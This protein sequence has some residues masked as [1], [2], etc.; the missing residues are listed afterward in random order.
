MRVTILKR[1]V[2]PKEGKWP[3]HGC[4]S[5]V[6]AFSPRFSSWDQDPQD[7][8]LDHF[9]QFQLKCCLSAE[10]RGTISSA[11]PITVSPESEISQL[12]ADFRE[13]DEDSNFS[14]FRV[15]RFSEWPEALHWIAFPVEILT[16]PDSLELPPPFSLKTPFFHWKV[17]RRIPFPKIGSD[18]HPIIQ[19]QWW[20]MASMQSDPCQPCL[21]PAIYMLHSQSRPVRHYILHSCRLTSAVASEFQIC[22]C[23]LRL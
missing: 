1:M 9:S 6:C 8:F 21:Q 15:R 22:I 18:Q 11:C 13:G 19:L 5:P 2:F 4:S 3:P 14:V 17:L 23:N 10:S 20:S 7:P 16:T 12:R